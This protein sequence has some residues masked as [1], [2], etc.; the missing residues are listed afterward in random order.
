MLDKKETRRHYSE[1]R[2]GLSPDKRKMLD[3]ILF[4]KTVNSEEFKGAEIILAYYPIKNEPDVLSIARYAL[5]C[6][7]R[8]GFPVSNT[9]TYEL[10]FKLVDDISQL[11]SG[12]YSIP[13]PKDSCKTYNNEVNTLCIVPALAFDRRGYRIGYGKGFYDRFLSKF[14]G[15]SVGLCYDDF[16]CEALPVENTDQKIKMIITDKEVLYVPE[17]ENK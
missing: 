16:L 1:K 6:G 8:V 14:R 3:D 15:T 17:K 12:A 9:D 13:E 5:L 10:T 7:K 2:N 11:N 4:D